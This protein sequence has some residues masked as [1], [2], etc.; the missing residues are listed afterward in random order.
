M[1]PKIPS[2]FLAF[3]ANFAKE[4][5]VC[6]LELKEEIDAFGNPL[7]VELSRLYTDKKMI[8][9]KSAKLKNDFPI[10]PDYGVSKEPQPTPGAIPDIVNFEKIF[11]FGVSGDGA[12]FC[13][14]FRQSPPSIIWWD[15]DHWRILAENFKDFI[16]LFEDQH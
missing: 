12:S 2:E 8:I 4:K 10:T 6:N 16:E 13:F 5:G 15:D 1:T 11:C 3:A 9:E 7:E 14:D